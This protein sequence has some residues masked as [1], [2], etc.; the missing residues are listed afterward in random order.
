MKRTV[1]Y[2]FAVFCALTLMTSCENMLTPEDLTGTYNGTMDFE[3]NIPN[4]T[5]ISIDDVANQVTVTKVNDVTVDVA[6][7]LNLSKYL[8]PTVQLLVGDELN[9]G[10]ATVRC[11]MTSV[12]GKAALVGTTEVKDYLLP[13]T[14]EYE[15]GVLELD[16]SLGELVSIEFEGTR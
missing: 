10:N 15:E 2:F 9:F 11:A 5:S 1:S 7:D 4:V 12:D 14:G 8:D 6:I 13:V 3:V 16:L